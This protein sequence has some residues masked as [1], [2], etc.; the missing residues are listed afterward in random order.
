MSKS[1]VD[2]SQ[3]FEYEFETILSFQFS[4]SALL[5]QL[6]SRLSWQ[7]CEDRSQGSG[8]VFNDS[9]GGVD[10]GR[11]SSKASSSF[12]S[13]FSSELSFLLIRIPAEGGT[14]EDAGWSCIIS[15]ALYLKCSIVVVAS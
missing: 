3:A 5:T 7:A 15:R 4:K 1:S 8:D 9:G 6:F 11:N 2:F 13:S 12:S 14:G 10:G